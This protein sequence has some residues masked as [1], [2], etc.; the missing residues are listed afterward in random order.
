MP[1]A[2][3]TGASLAERTLVLLQNS[4]KPLPRTMIR[5]QLRVNNQRL[6]QTL[7]N[8][9]KQ[10]LILQTSKGWQGLLKNHPEAKP[11]PVSL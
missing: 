7:V 6:G 9:D 1:T 2:T 5:K 11:A 10:G 4:P 8:L 3:T